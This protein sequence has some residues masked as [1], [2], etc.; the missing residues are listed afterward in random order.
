M[1][2]ALIDSE[3]PLLQEDISMGDIFK[4][5]LDVV[6]GVLQIKGIIGKLSLR[7][8][9]MSALINALFGALL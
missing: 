2:L 5:T 3:A 6:N 8:N 1:K 4:K 9:I 7:D